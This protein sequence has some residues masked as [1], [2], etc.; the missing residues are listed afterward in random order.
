M[1]EPITVIVKDETGT[2]QSVQA[3]NVANSGS[4]NKPLNPQAKNNSSKSTAGVIGTMVAMR[5]INYITS[6]VGKWTGNSRNQQAVNNVKQLIGY[7]IAFAV[8]PV[9]GAVSVALDGVTHALD[10]A[11]E[12][13]WEQIRVE[14]AQAR[15]GGKGGYRR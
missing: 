5:S 2:S 1:A 4:S 11:Y 13:K 14:Q 8:N 9:L 7:G 12:R 15:T 6:N 10:Y 3:G